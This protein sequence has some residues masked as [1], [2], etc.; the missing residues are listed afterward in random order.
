[1]DISANYNGSIASM[2]FISR[3]KDIV[4]LNDQGEYGDGYDYDY[5]HVDR[6]LRT[7]AS[8]NPSVSDVSTAVSNHRSESLKVKIS[9]VVGLPGISPS[10]SEMVLIEPRAFEEMPQVID[11]LLQQ[12]SVILNMILIRQEEAQRAVDFV[13]GGTYA[14]D[15]HYERIGDNI[16]LFTP[17][18][19]QVRTSSNVMT[20]VIT[21]PVRSGRWQAQ[22]SV[23]SGTPWA[24]EQ[25]A[26]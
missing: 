6:D 9:N 5:D 25:I 11:A 18:C 3:L 14:M 15:G 4:G 22:Q 7:S 8:R 23:T 19:V 2:G 16:F 20:E 12:K 10:T 13:A 17:N 26:Q 1:V 21:A 24:S